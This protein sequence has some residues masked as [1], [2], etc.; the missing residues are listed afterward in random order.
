MGVL[1]VDYLYF[2]FELLIG[3]FTRL[4]GYNLNNIFISVRESKAS[5]IPK[6]LA[7]AKF[8]WL[9]LKIPIHNYPRKVII[10]A[11]IFNRCMMENFFPKSV[12]GGKR[13]PGLQEHA[14]PILSLSV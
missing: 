13:M 12:E 6:L 5:I 14:L 1:P 8:Q 2:S 9:S 10:L 7:Q 3:N 11:K 4:T